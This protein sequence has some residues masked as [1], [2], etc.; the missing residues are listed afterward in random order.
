MTVVTIGL[1]SAPHGQHGRHALSDEY[2]GKSIDHQEPATIIMSSSKWDLLRKEMMCA[3][4][5]TGAK[6]L[7]PTNTMLPP[8]RHSFQVYQG[9]IPIEMSLVDE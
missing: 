4:G 8:H 3:L 1:A 9:L 7:M 6:L 5:A 2:E